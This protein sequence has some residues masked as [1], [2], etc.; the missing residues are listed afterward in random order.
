MK[1]LLLA[2]LFCL[3]ALAGYF[4]LGPALKRAPRAPGT[5]GALPPAPAPRGYYTPPAAAPPRAAPA[6]AAAGP[7]AQRQKPQSFKKAALRRKNRVSRLAE[8]GEA[9]G[10]G[11]DSRGTKPE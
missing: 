7:A 11:A 1:R 9:M 2:L 10:G 8:P 6:R 4:L 3:G 5:G